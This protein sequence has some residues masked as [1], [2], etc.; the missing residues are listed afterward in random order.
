MESVQYLESIIVNR[1]LEESLE[2]NSVLISYVTKACKFLQYSESDLKKIVLGVYLMDI[3]LQVDSVFSKD[4]ENHT[5]NGC[6]IM[7]GIEDVEIMK[8]IVLLHH[9]NNIGS[10]F[11]YGLIG[12]EIPNYVQIVS[13]CNDY[14]NYKSEGDLSQSK[15]IEELGLLYDENMIKYLTDFVFDR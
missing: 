3:G 7:S 5:I 6:A 4:Y 10:G 2:V 14:L 13:I 9:E 8:N 15:I 12:D 1:I 11:P